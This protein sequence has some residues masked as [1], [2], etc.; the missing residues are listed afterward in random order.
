MKSLR[1]LL[2]DTQTMKQVRFW[3]VLTAFFLIPLIYSVIANDFIAKIEEFFNVGVEITGLA[4]LGII[5]SF[6][7]TYNFKTQAVED[8]RDVDDE[9]DK[10]FTGLYDKKK[11]IDQDKIPKCM[12]YIDNQ[13]ETAQENANIRYTKSRITHHKNKLTKARLNKRKL[14]IR[15]HTRKIKRYEQNNAF[16]KKFIPLKYKDVLYNKNGLQQKERTYRDTY[17]D[18][19]TST[20]WWLKLFTTPITFL[21]FGGSLVSSVA[22]GFD[23]FELFMYYASVTIL[24]G[25]SCVIVYILVTRRVIHRTYQANLNMIDYI[26]DMMTQ[27]SIEPIPFAEL[28]SDYSEGEL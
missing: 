10:S 18:N 11:E 8:V 1:N 13:N 5:L 17:V 20:N 22:L 4:A 25:I 3:T 16:D 7:V 24:T 12:E 28:D 27:V 19:P 9:I 26:D 2:D 21:T 14:L 15:Y 6:F 23:L